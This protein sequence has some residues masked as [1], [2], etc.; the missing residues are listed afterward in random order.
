MAS[1]GVFNLPDVD[2]PMVALV[3]RSLGPPESSYVSGREGKSSVSS[4]IDFWTDSP[5]R[6]TFSDARDGLGLH[7][8]IQRGRKK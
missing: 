4:W 6:S 5:S 2:C 1:M 8:Q 3:T 7:G